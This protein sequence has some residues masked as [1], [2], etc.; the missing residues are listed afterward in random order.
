MMYW[1]IVTGHSGGLGRAITRQVLDT[2][3]YG[4]IGISRSQIADHDDIC[5][6]Y[7]ERLR[8]IPF[9]LRHPEALRRLY[10][11]QIAPLG[12]VGGLVNNA[13]LAY[14]DIATNL[15][16][17]RL[18]EMYQVNVFSAM[19]LTKI[20][21]RDM[22]LH[23]TKGSLVHIS[24]VSAHTGYKGLSMYASTKGAIEAFSK[25]IAREWGRKG[26]RSNCVSPGFMETAMSASLTLE[27]KE[28]IYKRNAMQMETSITDVA[29]TVVFL[30]SEQ[31]G[32]ITGTVLHADNGT[33]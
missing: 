19:Q 1:I 25:N 5:I 17:E 32:A 9:D 27:Q 10:Q 30:L 16:L 26:I 23:R 8:Q 2:T 28:K 22:L 4:I 33:L 15:N 6:R 14:D 11:E 13:A 21:I 20:A 18:Q 7:G 24:S 31:A 3:N 29:Q 12:P